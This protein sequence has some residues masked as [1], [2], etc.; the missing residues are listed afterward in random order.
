MVF[1]KMD[2]I[3]IKDNMGQA[4]LSHDKNLSEIYKE[5]NS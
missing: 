5:K 3:D 4:V 1:V 2:Q